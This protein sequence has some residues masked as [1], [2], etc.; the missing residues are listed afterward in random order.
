MITASHPANLLYITAGETSH[1]VLLKDLSRL[2]SR[3]N[4]NHNEKNISVN[5]V[6]M[7]KPVKRY[8]KKKKNI[9]KD[10]SYTGH[11]ES[12]SQKLMTKRN[13][14]KSSLQKQNTNCVYFLSSIWIS[15]VF[16]LN[17]TRMNHRHQNPSSANTS[18]LYHVRAAST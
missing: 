6:Y 18:I 2:I 7:T 16:Y 3:Q 5:V 8:C 4:N 9:W 1:Y 14:T 11:K 13:A 10:A 17:K 12:S 15:K